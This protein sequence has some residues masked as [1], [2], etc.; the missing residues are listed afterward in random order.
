[1]SGISALTIAADHDPAGQRA[2]KACGMRW[3]AA[4][5]TVRVVLPPEPGA[6]LNDVVAE[7]E[8]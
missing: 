3:A 4:G 5:A 6:D 7:I 8:A 2:A 1:M